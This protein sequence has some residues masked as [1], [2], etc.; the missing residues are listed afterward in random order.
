MSQ[1]IA[2]LIDDFT[3]EARLKKYSVKTIQSYR[4]SLS[5]FARFLADRKIQD[6][7]EV[8]L[9]V[10]NQYKGF[11]QSSQA[12]Y[13]LDTIH[14]KLRAVKR[15]FEYLEASQRLLF[16]PAQRLIMPPLGERLCRNILTKDQVSKILKAPN[17]S[18]ARG[19]RDRAL[20]ETLYSTGLRLSE[21][22]NLKVYDVDTEGGHLRIHRGK[23]A[24]DRIVP[25][26]KIACQWLKQYL[27]KTRPLYLLRNVED[28]RS[29]WIG[30]EGRSLK[31][32]WLNR[33]LNQY[34]KKAGIHEPVTVHT[35][36]R[37]FATH[38][39]Q[40]GAS[41]YYVQQLLGHQN[42]STLSQYIKLVP[43]DLKKAHQAH[44]P[45]ERCRKS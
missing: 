31:A 13:S 35:F 45:R 22:V 9:S 43:K 26:G 4:S 14:L 11:L 8:N 38:L 15:L 32:I 33:L 18:L 40:E 5:Q 3:E 29:L 39:L 20:L 44:H 42:G 25:L 17:T 21:C 27:E 37:S 23:G 16:N 19:I 1:S 41:P 7:R 28:Q 34:A 6:I 10:L 24:R 30:Q 12:Q 2:L 36:R